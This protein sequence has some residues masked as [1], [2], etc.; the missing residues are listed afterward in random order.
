VQEAFVRYWRQ[1][2]GIAGDPLALMLTSVRRAALD[3]LRRG[4]RRERREQAQ[5]DWMS[6]G[7]FETNPEGDERVNRLEEAVL[8]LPSEQREVLA[9]KIWS[10]LTFADIATQLELSPNTVASRYRYAL[11]NLRQKLAEVENHG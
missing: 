9:L 5:L 2:R 4:D 3:L 7:W 6:E 11:V 8:Q 10:D 1:Q